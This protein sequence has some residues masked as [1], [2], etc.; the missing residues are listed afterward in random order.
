MNKFKNLILLFIL[1]ISLIISYNLIPYINSKIFLF[2]FPENHIILIW[3][4]RCEI[5]KTKNIENILKNNMNGI[6][7]YTFKN[8]NYS[9]SYIINK[10]LSENYS[11]NLPIVLF[12]NK[13][14]LENNDKS[15][16]LI[17]PS[18]YISLKNQWIFNFNTNKYLFEY[19]CE[20][21]IDDDWDW[22]IDLLDETCIKNKKYLEK[23]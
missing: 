13:K 9:N 3:D 5:C 11:T 8:F 4:D 14:I 1:C 17:L 23:N 6:E 18:W 21:N 19:D 16:F 12:S 10:I 2:T 15:N 20:N 22:K 7:E